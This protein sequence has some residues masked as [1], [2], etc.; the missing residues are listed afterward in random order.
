[1]TSSL[2]TDQPNQQLGDLFHI[3]SLLVI[4]HLERAS[5]RDAAQSEL[6]RTNLNIL[7]LL[8][9]EKRLTMRELSRIHGISPS[10]VTKSIDHLEHLGLVEREYTKADRRIIWVRITSKGR[11][12]VKYFR[13]S[14]TQKIEQALTDLSQKERVLLA[15]TLE[16]F[17]KGGMHIEPASP[18]ST[19]IERLD[20]CLLHR[21]AAGP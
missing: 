1:M 14:Y 2:P 9:I 15:G 4:D 12:F 19:L 18:V 10:A 17:I 5:L 3:L 16:A 21:Y 11:R 20:Q 13:Q 8:D 6:N 7:L